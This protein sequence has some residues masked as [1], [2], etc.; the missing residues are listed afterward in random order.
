VSDLAPGSIVH[1]ASG[2]PLM[3]VQ[4]IRDGLDGNT[5][6]VVWFDGNELRHAHLRRSALVVGAGEPIDLDDLQD[7]WDYP[8]GVVALAESWASIDG[9]LDWFQ[10][11]RDLAGAHRLSAEVSRSNSG[12]YDG[13]CE[14]ALEMMRRLLKRGYTVERDDPP[15]ASSLP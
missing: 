9:K 5:V 6:H 1:L 10:R 14:E 8:E 7:A 3:T 11:E 4:E 2:G 13:Y 12:T 15:R